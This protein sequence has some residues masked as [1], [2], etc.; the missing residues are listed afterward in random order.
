[1][2]SKAQERAT[3]LNPKFPQNISYKMTKGINNLEDKEH[4]GTLFS[5]IVLSTI[6]SM[7]RKDGVCDAGNSTLIN[8]LGSNKSTVSRTIT[9]LIRGGYVTSEWGPNRYGKWIWKLIPTAKAL[10]VDLTPKDKEIVWAVPYCI[11]DMR[12]EGKSLLHVE[13]IVL[14]KIRQ[15]TGGLRVFYGSL[16]DL[17]IELNLPKSTVRRAVK[18]L[19]AIGELIPSDNSK[20]GGKQVFRVA[21]VPETTAPKWNYQRAILSTPCKDNLRST[22]ELQCHENFANIVP[23]NLL[24]CIS[25]NKGAQ[26]VSEESK[27]E[28]KL[29]GKELAALCLARA[30]RET[31]LLTNPF[32]RGEQTPR[33]G[34]IAVGQQKSDA[35]V[36]PALQAIH[37]LLGQNTGNKRLSKADKAALYPHFVALYPKKTES[38]YERFAAAVFAMNCT[39]TERAWNL[40]KDIAK[41][42]T[43]GMWNPNHRAFDG[44]QVPYLANYLQLDAK[45]RSKYNRRLR[46][47]SPMY[48]KNKRTEFSSFS[49]VDLGDDNYAESMRKAANAKLLAKIESLS[50]ISASL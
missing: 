19:D 24:D 3:T 41:A 46:N 4:L 5:K 26:P 27:G 47:W 17:A 38:H 10:A 1:M 12:V 45:S 7:A 48:R 50:L 11:R 32:P 16:S 23:R 39:T 34:V 13:Q 25:A 18:R 30:E 15:I 35:A 42:K 14:S 9:T 21:N 8:E 37:A 49:A 44:S 43:E 20:A 28:T 36:D 31:R 2:Q 22:S 33:G 6:L 40:A 29:Q